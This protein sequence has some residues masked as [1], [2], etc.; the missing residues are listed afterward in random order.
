[1]ITCRQISIAVFLPPGKIH[2]YPFSQLLLQE[3]GMCIKEENSGEI[4]NDSYSKVEHL[5]QEVI[6][7]SRADYVVV[8]TQGRRVVAQGVYSGMQPV[9]DLCQELAL[10]ICK[11]KE[12]EK[13]TAYGSFE[14]FSFNSGFFYY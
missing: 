13:F 4:K 1:M 10:Q 5:P 14:E 11:E 12:F 2:L 3:E 9:H 7:Y 6:E 8:A